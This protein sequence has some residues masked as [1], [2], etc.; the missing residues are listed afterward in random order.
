MTTQPLDRDCDFVDSARAHQ[1]GPWVAYVRELHLKRSR[2]SQP[3]TDFET[4]RDLVD[5]W[6]SETWYKSSI[7]RRVSHPAYLKIIGLGPKAVPWILQELRQ[8]PD[9]W[10]AA[11]EAITREN[12]SPNATSFPELRDA[13]LRWGEVNG[14]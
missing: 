12:P 9:Y 5:Q 6:R 2:C 10:F 7:S 4:F 14:R 1:R 3:K 13:W 11:L 8:E